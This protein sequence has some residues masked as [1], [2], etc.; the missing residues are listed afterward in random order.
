MT[1]QS[2]VDRPLTGVRVVDLSSTFMGPYCTLLLAQMGA[3]V[4]KVESPSGDVVRYV[5]DHRGTGM[6]PVFLNANQGKRSIVLD[7]KD[8]AGR[9]A[10]LRLVGTADVFVH[11]MRP[12]AVRR[13]GLGFEDV[14]ATN[15]RTV[16]CAVRGFGADGPYRDKAAYDDVIQAASGLAAVQGGPGEPTY[17]KTPIADKAT[18]LI[19][20][21]AIGAALYQRERTGRGQEI[22]V[23]MLES[24]VSFTLLDQQGGYVYDPPRGP[25]GYAR[26]SSPYRKPYR[27][28]DGYVSVMVYTDAQWRSFFG[29]VDRPELAADPRYLSI[30]ERTL[31]IDELYRLVEQE[32][33]RRT[34]AEWLTVLDAQGIPA[35]PVWTVPELFEDEH[36][37]AT[38]MFQGL[39]HPTEGR[40]RLARFPVFFSASAPMD[41]RPAP[42]LGEHGAE[43]LAE[44]GYGPEE[45]R[46]LGGDVEDDEGA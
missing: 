8:P 42:R 37:R 20:V 30:T 13:L 27:T 11:N 3:D 28:A 39:T 5:A 29:L 10:L 23:P 32:L 43:V 14:A 12:D 40:L 24:M 16:Y 26:T 45:I 25:A 6:G 7:L 36:L 46:A 38:G 22:E 19:A 44:L 21:G 34:T 2:V 35:M 15:P 17:V 18:A 33:L 31:H 41:C 4:I 1:G 9:D